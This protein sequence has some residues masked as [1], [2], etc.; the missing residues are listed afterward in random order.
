MSLTKKNNNVLVVDCHDVI[1][2]L[3]NRLILVVFDNDVI[4]V[5]KNFVIFFDRFVDIMTIDVETNFKIDD[6]MISK[7]VVELTKMSDVVKR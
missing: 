4:D 7:F 3:I 5:T 2:N 6:A 1:N